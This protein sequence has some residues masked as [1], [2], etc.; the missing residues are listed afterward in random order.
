[1]GNKKTK[2]WNENWNRKST[3]LSTGWGEKKCGITVNI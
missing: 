3:A 2:F 1:M